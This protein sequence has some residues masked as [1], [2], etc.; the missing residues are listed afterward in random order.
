MCEVVSRV[1]ATWVLALDFVLSAM[2]GP[3][4]GL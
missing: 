2:D 4:Y 3:L 1:S